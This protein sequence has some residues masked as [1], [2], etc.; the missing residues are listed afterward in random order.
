MEN[1][2]PTSAPDSLRKRITGLGLTQGTVKG[3]L[4]TAATRLMMFVV[5][6]VLILTIF[7]SWAQGHQGSGPLIP[8][9]EEMR[10]MVLIF[11][12][13]LV[14]VS[15]VWGYYPRSS[16]ARLYSGVIGCGVLIVYGYAV[17]LTGGLSNVLEAMGWV[18]PPLVAFGI[19]CYLAVRCAFKFDRDY[20]YFRTVQIRT[21]QEV[22]IFKPA[23]GRGEFDRR[24][25]NPSAAASTAG[26]L[27]YRPLVRWALIFLLL[28]FLLSVIGF[29]KTASEATYLNVLGNICAVILLMNYRARPRPRTQQITKLLI[30]CR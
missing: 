8:G 24:L 10:T 1:E 14:V 12:L 2:G 16:K 20:L 4:F 19:V 13:V 3:A 21:G 26:A 18:L 22:S 5:V 6:P 11:G 17:L 28:L 25:G 29:G 7:L 23:L 9:L 15:F 30:L 27:V